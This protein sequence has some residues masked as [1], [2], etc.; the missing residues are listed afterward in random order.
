MGTKNLMLRGRGTMAA[1]LVLALAVVL[2][3]CRVDGV[4][5]QP[6]PQLGE[7]AAEG[8]AAEAAAADPVVEA[9]GP[10]IYVLP[11]T[12]PPVVPPPTTESPSYTPT[13]APTYTP[14]SA[15]TFSPTVK[16][17]RSPTRAPALG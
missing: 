8:E 6:N 10:V 3:A 13:S 14:T 5:Y 17:T 12:A 4:I 15:P 9:P 2:M 11:Q 7:A 16:P 1:L